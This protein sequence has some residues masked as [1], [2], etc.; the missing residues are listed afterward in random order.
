MTIIRI[1]KAKK[2]IKAQG[3]IIR[4]AALRR[5]HFCSKD[6]K[7]LVHEDVLRQ[8]RRGYYAPPSALE[9]MDSLELVSF[10]I[11]E[12]VVSF[13]SAAHFHDLTTVIPRSVDI[14]L[15]ATMRTPTLPEQPPITIYKSVPHVF[16][17]GIQTVRKNGYKVKI[18]DKERTV[19]DFFRMRLKIGKDVAF[20]VLKTYMSGKPNLQRLYEYAAALQIER[21]LHPYLEVLA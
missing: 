14:T 9:D 4:S 2:L 17:L 19:C 20:E 16:R 12:G 5:A 3:P 15:P 13:F 1:D 18:Y 6:V 10:L 7:T 11:P 21:V 8:I